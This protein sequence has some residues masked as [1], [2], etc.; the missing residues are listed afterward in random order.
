MSSD[1]AAALAAALGVDVAGLAR[2]TGGA[3][4]ETWRFDGDG[5]PLVL[6]RD[7]PGRPGLPGSMGRGAAALRAAPAPGRAAPER[8]D[9][10][11]APAWWG[12]AGTVMR[13]AEGEAIAG[14]ILRDEA[15]AGGRSVLAA[16]CGEFLA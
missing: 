3:S 13:R 7:P 12:S 5:E 11:A 16:Q 15:Y 1:L 10:T 8:V 4:R 2:L 14:P 9:A 6:R